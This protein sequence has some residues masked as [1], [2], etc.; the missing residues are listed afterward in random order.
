M[1]WSPLSQCLRNSLISQVLF[2]H[3]TRRTT[4]F[5]KKRTWEVADVVVLLISSVAHGAFPILLDLRSIKWFPLLCC[6][7]FF[8]VLR[9]HRDSFIA[10]DRN[11]VS[12]YF[13]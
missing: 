13:L 1:K 11:L 3:V 2:G 5:T 6:M 4:S 10:W 8:H 12:L 7:D 9:M